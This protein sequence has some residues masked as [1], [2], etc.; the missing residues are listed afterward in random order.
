EAACLYAQ[1]AESFPHR[2]QLE[3]KFAFEVHLFQIAVP[4][5]LG[6]EM[7]TFA[8]QQEVRLARRTAAETATREIRSGVEAFVRECVTELR[9]QTARLCEEMLG[10]MRSGKTQGVHQKTFNR[11]VKFIDEF[12]SLNFAG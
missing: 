3:S 1:I 6:M 9:Q 5:S 4:E 7:V 10:S 12:K 8:E 11:L 2:E